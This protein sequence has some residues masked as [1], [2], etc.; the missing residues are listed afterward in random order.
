LIKRIKL[1]DDLRHSHG[2]DELVQRKEHDVEA[3]T[4]A[5]ALRTVHLEFHFHRGNAPHRQKADLEFGRVEERIVLGCLDIRAHRVILTTTSLHHVARGVERSR[6]GRRWDA[7]R[8]DRGGHDHSTVLAEYGMQHVCTT[9][10][11]RC[12][13]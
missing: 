2:D 10:L 5:S 3:D 11:E 4:K 6:R 1:A 7:V 8:L 12:A 9:A 13:K